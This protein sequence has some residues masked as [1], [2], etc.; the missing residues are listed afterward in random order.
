MTDDDLVREIAAIKV[1][2]DITR[3]GLLGLHVT[4]KRL[5]ALIAKYDLMLLAATDALYPPH[6][7]K[8]NQK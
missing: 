2:R 8:E 3:K 7:A 4:E 1:Q 5:S 6:F